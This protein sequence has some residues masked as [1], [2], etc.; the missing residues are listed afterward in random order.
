MTFPFHYRL[1]AN[2][3]TPEYPSDLGTTAM[4]SLYLAY[5]NISQ[6]VAGK[7]LPD[8]VYTIH[9]ITGLDISTCKVRGQDFSVS[10]LRQGI[11][12]A[13]SDAENLMNEIMFGF[14]VNAYLVKDIQDNSAIG[15]DGYSWVTDSN[16][17]HLRSGIKAFRDYMRS[18]PEFF[19]GSDGKTFS[20]TNLT[21]W[22]QKTT[23]LL[24]LILLLFHITT[25]QPGR[26]SENS[27]LLYRNT[28]R[29]RRHILFHYNE[30]V[31]QPSH[32]KPESAT[33]RLKKVLRFPCARLTKILVVYLAFIREMEA[34]ELLLF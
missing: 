16:N 31:V 33:Q 26:A 14:Q 19:A 21:K 4:A 32:L 29:I 9:P 2:P 1:V 10:S 20:R 30:M 11:A 8:I 27:K 22:L 7:T 12:N 24:K 3:N 5:G 18:R 23:Q 13:L 28:Q 34:Y 15:A 25:G 6:F 17:Y